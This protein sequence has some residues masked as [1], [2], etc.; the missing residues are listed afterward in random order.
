MKGSTRLPFQST[1]PPS[2]ADQISEQVGASMR[3]A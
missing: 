3:W 2:R 1:E